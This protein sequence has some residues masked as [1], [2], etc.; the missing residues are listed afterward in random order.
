MVI[1]TIRREK[2][3][4][5]IAVKNTIHIIKIDLQIERGLKC[6]HKSFIRVIINIRVDA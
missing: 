5:K 6:K 4:W 3:E 1:S 2:E